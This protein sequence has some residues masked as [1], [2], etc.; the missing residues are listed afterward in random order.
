[1]LFRSLRDRDLAHMDSEDLLTSTDI[2]QG[3]NYLT[4]KATRTQQGGIKHIGPVG[5]GDQPERSPY[6]T[7]RANS[8]PLAPCSRIFGS[9]RLNCNTKG[10]PCRQFLKPSLS[11]RQLSGTKTLKV[12]STWW[13][14]S[15]FPYSLRCVN[16]CRVTRMM[17]HAPIKRLLKLNRM[18]NHS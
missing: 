2:G 5:C 6:R 18:K 11:R 12:T 15:K 7:I 1:M 8:C 4:V 10:F 13:E 3:Y 9:L 17:P 14:P 16:P